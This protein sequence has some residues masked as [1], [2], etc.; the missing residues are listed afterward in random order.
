MAK[1]GNEANL[2]L[3]LAETTLEADI[4]RLQ[5][6]RDRSI[7]ESVKELYTERI[8][9]INEAIKVYRRIALALEK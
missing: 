2:I 8:R 3:Q 5:N 1:I 6:M 7:V 9:G 4:V